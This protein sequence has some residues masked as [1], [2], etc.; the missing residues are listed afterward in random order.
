MNKPRPLEITARADIGGGPEHVFQLASSLRERCPIALASPTDEPYWNRFVSIAGDDN[1]LPIPHRR[2]SLRALGQLVAFV[3]KRRIN[4]IHSHGKGAGLYG[5]LL[6]AATGLPCVHTFHGF[7][8]GEYGPLAKRAYIALERG[9]GLF[10]KSGICVSQGEFE[11]ISEV[12]LLGPKKLLTI[13]N[14]VQISQPRQKVP[15]APPLRLVAVSRFDYQKNTEMMID[16]A[17]DLARPENGIGFQMVIYGRGDG[18][19]ETQATIAERGLSQHVSLPGA[20][21]DIRQ[22]LREAHVFLSTSRWEGMPLAVLEAMSESLPVVASDVV[23]NRDVVDHGTTGL[24]FQPDDALNA[25]TM[26]KDLA[27]PAR[28]YQLGMAGRA[29]VEAKYSIDRMSA[30]VFELYCSVV[31]AQSPS[32]ASSTVKRL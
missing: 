3:R 2:F 14:G 22:Q 29:R 31:N 32:N 5:R 15:P 27:D 28:Q 16:I 10:T 13:E 23:G 6:A 30:R 26:I 9:L 7:H 20:T 19:D 12:G 24:L 17:R 11:Q 1:T 21:T 18:F 25:V 8:V 4:V